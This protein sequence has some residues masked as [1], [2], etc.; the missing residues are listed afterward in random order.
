[1]GNK[2]TYVRHSKNRGLAAARNT[3]IKLSRGKYIAYLDDDDMYYPDHLETLVA[4]LHDSDCKVAYTD[5][6][7]SIQVKE[8]GQYVTKKKDLPYSYDFD[9]DQILVTNYIPV[10]C[11]MHEKACLDETGLFD[12][13]LP[14]F[15]D[16]D[17]W[18]RMSRRFQ[19]QHIKKTT[20]EFTW[21]NDGS[22]M[23]SS[24]QAEFVNTGRMIQKRYRKYAERTPH[25]LIGQRK[26]YMRDREKLFNLSNHPLVSI[27]I[28][29]H[30]NEEQ[31]LQ[32]LEG[33]SLNT[34]YEPYEVIL[35]DSNT[36]RRESRLNN[37]V[38]GDVKII[39]AEQNSEYA[40]VCNRGAG[41]AAGRYFVFLDSNLIPQKGW[42][43][44]LVKAIECN[45]AAGIA[46]AKVLHSDNTVYH[47]G[48][49]IN[50]GLAVHHVFQGVSSNN[51]AVNKVREYDAVAKSCILI[52]RNIFFENGGFAVNSG[53]DDEDVDICAKAR[54]K[55]YKVIYNPQSVLCL[56]PGVFHKDMKIEL[57]PNPLQFFKKR[58]GEAKKYISEDNTVEA[59]TIIA[60]LLDIY[61]HVD[62]LY[63]AICDLYVKT[64]WYDIPEEWIRKAVAYDPSFIH[65]F[66]ELI[67][68]LISEE[69]YLEAH[70]IF[71]I[72]GD[73]LPDRN[74]CDKTF[75]HEDKINKSEPSEI[76]FC[77]NLNL[78]EKINR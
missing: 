63:A 17:L 64:G 46:G 50:H 73:T 51:P 32:C 22:T 43:T 5:A 23:T 40:D 72:M 70:E 60:G 71:T 8:N 4:Y 52:E 37:C 59:I 76:H 28:P 44:E 68:T 41:M 20:A 3:G 14:V 74:T 35:V 11:V 34:E 18:I 69:R 10:N 2:I 57:D 67:P 21:K 29:L 53:N 7:R 78:K 65:T 38:K 13:T 25:I 56:Y 55:G 6:Y 47:A 49:V 30:N 39:S 1:M 12:E 27:V 16:W 24:G 54:E 31:V 36:D 48:I 15:E 45:D 42:L 75:P 66:K 19:M 62:D 61:P 9:Y 58:I 77:P 26:A 33:I